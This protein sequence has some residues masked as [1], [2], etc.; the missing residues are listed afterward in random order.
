MKSLPRPKESKASHRS[1]YPKKERH[2]PT[3]GASHHQPTLPKLIPDAV[4]PLEP[5]LCAPNLAY[6]VTRSP[7]NELPIYTL[8]KRG[9]NLHLTKIKKVDGKADVLRDELQAFLG[10]GEKEATINTTTGHIMLKGHHKPSIEKFL[11]QRMF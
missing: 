8:R 4:E 11:R 3:R 5:Q 10:L 9:G 6:F 7:S 1:N 2:Y